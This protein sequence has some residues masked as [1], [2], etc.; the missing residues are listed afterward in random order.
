MPRPPSPSPLFLPRP[1]PC[2][3][4]LPLPSSFAWDARGFALALH[5]M[6]TV[7]MTTVEAISFKKKIFNYE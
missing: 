2:T 4:L 7:D 6:T 3:L 1:P 5:D